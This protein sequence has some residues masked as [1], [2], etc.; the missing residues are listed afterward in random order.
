MKSA[1]VAMTL[2]VSLAL[3]VPVATDQDGK[4]TALEKRQCKKH[5]CCW[6]GECSY[7]QCLN[8]LCDA[9]PE[10]LTCP[11]TCWDSCKDC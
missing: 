9:F 6:G 3:A 10:S 4:T 5:S 11:P 7:W 2:F 1:I 8:N